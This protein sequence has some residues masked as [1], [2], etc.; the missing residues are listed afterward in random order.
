MS[1]GSQA[2][3]PLPPTDREGEIAVYFGNLDL[4]SPDAFVLEDKA[5]AT[6]GA[7][8]TFILRNGELH[9]WLV[10]PFLPEAIAARAD[11]YQQLGLVSNP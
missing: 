11:I 10:V 4:Y 6:P 9:D 2:T 1:D 7:D 3:E 8:F 5:L